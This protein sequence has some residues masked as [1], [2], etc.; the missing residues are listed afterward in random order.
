MLHPTVKTTFGPII[1]TYK[2]DY[3]V[4]LGIPYAAPPIQERRFLPPIDPTPWA[5][6]LDC[7]KYAPAPYQGQ[8]R[9]GGFYQIEFYPTKREVSEDCLYLN[10]WTPALKGQNC[11]VLFWIHG[12]GFASG[13]TNELPF[14]GAA[15]AKNGCILV[16][17]GYRVGVFSSYTK[18]DSPYIG[19]LGM[20]DILKALHWVKNNIERF[21]GNKDLVTV[22]GQSAGGAAVSTLLASPLTKELFSRAII[23][24]AGGVNTMFGAV[25]NEK[26]AAD[27][28]E[29]LSENGLTHDE[30]RQLSAEEIHQ[31]TCQ[32][33]DQHPGSYHFPTVDHRFLF[34]TPGNAAKN[35]QIPDMPIMT[36]SVTCDYFY[37]VADKADTYADQ[38]AI[39]KQVYLQEAN[40]ILADCLTGPEDLA[41]LHE[42][43]D[44]VKALGSP[45]SLAVSVCRHHHTPV[46][47]YHM[48][49]TVPGSQMRA[50]HS[51]DL[52]YVFG[53]LKRSWRPF[54]ELDDRMSDYMIKA[55]CRFAL[56]GCPDDSG[57]WQPFTLDNPVCLT[58]GD[59]GLGTK[60]YWDQPTIRSMITAGM[61]Q[62]EQTD[63]D[64]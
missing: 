19:N 2:D 9:I 8:P 1:G 16:T 11:P 46:Y 62:E 40:A 17:V 36:G 15:F 29:M 21:G 34:D 14:D 23:Q 31:M 60:K 24:S 63:V 4:F 50:Y 20:W 53:T 43:L 32:F 61:L 44:L 38:V 42:T 52:W 49:R 18:A 56:T 27:Y 7:E 13:G 6:P 45:H 51:F 39:I 25:S 57:L 5:E 47:L 22:F 35:G 28:E 59:D 48:D 54:G 26:K 64:K 30:F 3:A 37:P 12:G 58:I 41:S 33:D 10:V 55:W